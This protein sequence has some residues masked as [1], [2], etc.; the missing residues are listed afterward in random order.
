[1]DTK[2]L[3]LKDNTWLFRR[4]IPK[5][6]QF[7]YHNKREFIQSTGAEKGDLARAHKVRDAI[8][9]KLTL[10]FD[11]LKNEIKSGL[12]KTPQERLALENKL[13]IDQ[14][15]KQSPELLDEALD[16]AVDDAIQFVDIDVM[17]SGGS[18][19]E[20]ILRADTTGKAKKYL[21]VISSNTFDSFIDEYKKEN[22][23]DR[24]KARGL[25]QKLAK[26]R[27]FAKYH[28]T[29]QGIDKPR[30][31]S[32]K[33]YLFDKKKL[34][35]KTISGYLQTLGQYWD[36][37]ADDMGVKE[38]Q[39]GNPF[40]NI[41]LPQHIKAE[42][43]AWRSSYFEDS[44]DDIKE[45]LES[46][47][48][49]LTPN[50]KHAIIIAMFTGA[51]IEEICSIKKEEI[52]QHNQ[53]RCIYFS[54]SKTDRYHSFGRRYVPIASHYDDLITKLINETPGAYLLN[55]TVLEK[56]KRRS[57]YLSRKFGDLKEK[58]GHPKKK[59]RVGISEEEQAT[60]DFHSFRT[61]LNTFFKR[62]N[63]EATE[64][65]ALCGWK[66]NKTKTM[67]DDVYLRLEQS[68][69]Y[70]KRKNDIDTIIKLY[71]WFNESYYL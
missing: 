39:K 52:K 64:R 71:P 7:M 54:A 35:P 68:Y 47:S 22:Q 56:Y 61:T 3:K 50:L 49:L 5:E 29:I 31:T 9:S 32:Y 65:G 37:L 44:V 55:E 69:P 36:F 27:S 57:K 20:A 67:A 42:R 15:R 23:R 62:Q 21:D 66:E 13:K 11:A 12:V 26:I 19:A 16:D 25:D 45:I 59:T 60:R 53:V 4:K 14:A 2:Y 43:L 58:L 8:N 18:K 38:A 41:K 48:S 24:I 28:S 1:M 30:V 40:R 10:Q 70:H 6:Y 63:I 33:N 51:R 17:K 46:E 34:T